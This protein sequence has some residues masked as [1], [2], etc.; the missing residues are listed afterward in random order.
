M[1]IVTTNGTVVPGQ[2]YAHGPSAQPGTSP[3]QPDTPPAQPD[4]P[5]MDAA[6]L[7]AGP[8]P[9]HD[10]VARALAVIDRSIHPNRPE[11]IATVER[12]AQL[13][14]TH[15]WADLSMR[16][17]LLHATE[18][19][20]AGDAVRAA[21][22][23]HGVNTWAKEQ[24]DQ[25]LVA[26]SHNLLFALFR[27]IGD[28]AEALNQAL[29]AVTTTPADAEPWVRAKHLTG[30]AV[31]LVLTKSVGPARRRFAEALTLAEQDGSPTVRLMVLNNFAYAM[32]DTGDLE[33]ARA[34]AATIQDL[35]RQGVPLKSSHVETLARIEIAGGRFAEAE[36]LLEPLVDQPSGPVHTDADS[37]PMC[38]LTLAEGQRLR[39]ATEQ[40]QATLDRCARLVGER[41]LEHL[42]AMLMQEQARLY[43]A[44]RRYRPAYEEL[45]R[46]QEAWLRA[47]DAQREVRANVAHAM[48]EVEEALR[49][50]DQFRELATRDPLT[51][52]HNRRLLADRLPAAIAAA[53]RGGEPFSLALFDLDRF[54]QINDTCSH[55]VGD[56]VLQQV[57][58]LTVAAVPPTASVVRMGGEEFLVILPGSDAEDAAVQGE[59][60]RR[61][62]QDHDWSSITGTL[63]VTVSVGVTTCTGAATVSGL[64]STADRQMYLA[65]QA[66]RNRVVSDGTA[67]SPAPDPDPTVREP[68]V[69]GIPRPRSRRRYRGDGIPDDADVQ[70]DPA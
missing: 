55:E 48:Y 13:A 5:P 40:A 29:L 56:L 10:D 68:A 50:R 32:Y 69:R 60:V 67:A 18:A 54:K 61:A 15:G 22:L 63:P 19:L 45:L 70:E 64:L 27:S 53:D 8:D 12:A 52:L 9:S 11:D 42:A 37:Y 66:G 21:R 41:G 3:A 65:K 34:Y 25:L 58:A 49:E 35:A 57:A 17:D 20:T 51:G 24:Q 62:V 23:G 39:G 59:R 30:L 16:A 2:L 26:R 1:R 44:R 38:L 47:Q 14:G 36:R 6:A 43:A 4:T 31:G 7:I 33:T 28:H 46:F